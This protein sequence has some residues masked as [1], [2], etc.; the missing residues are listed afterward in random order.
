MLFMVIESFKDGDFRAVGARFE[1]RGR[2]LPD[3]VTYHVSWIE[4]SGARCFQ[5]ME[6]PHRE[7][8]NDW[9]SR[10]EDLVDFEVVPVER[11]AEFWARVRA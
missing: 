8:L 6:A 4:P 2:M 5:V 7:A 11:S 10:W 3:S 1:Q 9:T